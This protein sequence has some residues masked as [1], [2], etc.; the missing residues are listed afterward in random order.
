MW[1]VLIYQI[2][3]KQSLS[4][5]VMLFIARE[6]KYSKEKNI[7]AN[8]WE[9]LLKTKH[10]EI[11][12]NALQVSWIYVPSDTFI[13]WVELFWVWKRVTISIKRTPHINLLFFPNVFHWPWG[14][15]KFKIHHYF[16]NHQEKRGR[17]QTITSFLTLTIFTF[18]LFKELL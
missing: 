15:I 10:S 9:S 8:N 13:L 18:Q 17:W 1:L 4:K 14:T 5:T 12:N 2:F 7:P 3:P 6:I 11:S 16:A